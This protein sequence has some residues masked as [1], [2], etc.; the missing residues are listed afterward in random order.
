MANKISQCNSCA[1]LFDSKKALK[2]HIDKTHRIT[3]EKITA[4]T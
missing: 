1:R 3:D 4:I 2:E